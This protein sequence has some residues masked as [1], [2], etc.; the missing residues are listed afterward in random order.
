MNFL[1][2]LQSV[3]KLF[4]KMYGGRGGEG[5]K[6]PPVQIGLSGLKPLF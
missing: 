6:V 4:T 1:T 3:E 5:Q 2:Q